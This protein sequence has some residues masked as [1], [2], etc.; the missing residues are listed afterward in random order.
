MT[1][2]TP[3]AA[4]HR[5]ALLLASSIAIACSDPSSSVPA[6]DW[7]AFVRDIHPVLLRD[8]GFTQ[9]H[10]DADR[11]FHVY[12]PGRL[13]LDDATEP[14]DPATSEEL[15]ASYQ[16]ARSMAVAQDDEL[17]LLLRKVL[18]G[19]GH[20]GLDAYG[21]SVYPDE[22]DPSYELLRAWVEGELWYGP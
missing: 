20:R 13:R 9:C 10:G 14:F 6:P 11:F 8:C 16:R 1:G 5:V 7:D 4:P 15:W 22:D 17:P 3:M 19:G 18:P 2:V 21:G 12:G